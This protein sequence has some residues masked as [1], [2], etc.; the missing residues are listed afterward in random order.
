MITDL[1]EQFAWALDNL[2]AV[3]RTMKASGSAINGISTEILF[4]F[5]KSEINGLAHGVR[6]KDECLNCSDCCIKPPAVIPVQGIDGGLI[7]PLR[8]GLKFSRQPCWWLRQENGNFKCAIHA[9]GEKPFT[10]LSFQC[11]SRDKLEE[12]ISKT[13]GGK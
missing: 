10:C 5:A 1:N 2:L 11:E 7:R 12:N 8:Y 9:S 3:L 6:T 13:E 4:N